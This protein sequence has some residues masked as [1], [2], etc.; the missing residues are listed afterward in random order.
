MS[1]LAMKI[2]LLVVCSMLLPQVVMAEPTYDE[3]GDLIPPDSEKF[4]G[5]LEGF[6]PEVSGVISIIIINDTNYKIDDDTVYRNKKGRKSSLSGFTNGM[7]VDYYAIEHLVTNL[8]VS[9]NPIE[10]AEQPQKNL[11][12]DAPVQNDFHQENGVWIN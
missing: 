7:L 9:A 11:S 2:V 8:S 5:T 10:N 12:P 4:S 1:R 3:H 6:G